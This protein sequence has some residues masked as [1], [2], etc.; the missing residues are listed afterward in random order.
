MEETTVS[1]VDKVIGEVPKLFELANT[2]FNAVIDNPILLM[3]FSVGLIGT[4]LGIFSMLKNT[5]RG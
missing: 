3:F 4:G 2:C 1:V 5:A